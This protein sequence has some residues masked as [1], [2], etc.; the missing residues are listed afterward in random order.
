[1]S[2]AKSRM[3]SSYRGMASLSRPSE[4]SRQPRTCPNIA[5]CSLRACEYSLRIARNPESGVAIPT[6]PLPHT[7]S[8]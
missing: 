3:L 5:E 6:P 2:I 7:A 8:H 1:M 4:T